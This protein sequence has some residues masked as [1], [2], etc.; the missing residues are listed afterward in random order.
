MNDSF[1]ATDPTQD[2]LIAH[3]PPSGFAAA[4]D[5][6]YLETEDKD[7]ETCSEW[8]CSPMAVVAR[9]RNFQHTGWSRCIELTDPDG[10]VHRWYVL[11][12][13]LSTRSST[14]L[15]G[16][17]DRGLRFAGTPS[18]KRHLL[19][20]IN[21]WKPTRRYVTT[22][23]LGWTD[24]NCTSFV[25][26]NERV[27]G[28]G[29]LVFLN[30]SAR[31]GAEGMHPRGTLKEWRDAVAS[32]CQGNPILVASVSLAFAGPLPGLL[33]LE[34]AGLHL[35]GESSKGKSSAM[36]AA[37][38][39][40]GSPNLM[41]SWRATTNALEGA[42]AICNGALMPFDEFGEAKGKEIG[43]AIYMLLNGQGKARMAST[44]QLRAQ[45][46]WRAM[47]LSTGELTL[48]DKMAEA[49]KK[50]MAGQE[51]R[52]IDIQADARRFGAFDDLHGVASAA[53]FSMQL[54]HSV[55][56][57][58]G[59]A[60]PEF[61]ERL[62][63]SSSDDRHR[64]S[65][66]RREIASM[67][68]RASSGARDGQTGRVIGHFALIALA[69]ELATRYGITGWERGTA[70]KAAHELFDNW[71]RSRHQSGVGQIDAAVQRT[72]S[73]LIAN[74]GSSFEEI[75]GAPVA[76]RDGYRDARWF[77]IFGDAWNRIH[78]GHSP[79]EQAR[80]L[81]AGGWLVRGDGAN[82]KSKTPFGVP[83]RPRAFK[84]KVGILHDGV[85]GIA[86]E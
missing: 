22:D 31:S 41:F 1:S 15:A 16:L 10:V 54:K 45:N 2:P 44:G 82:L 86:A 62:V 8:L 34:P 27:I 26:G 25:L 13:W 74:G 84:I 66:F 4:H 50:T 64:F 23:R 21:R 52:L 77:Y 85:D 36:K 20:L 57:H 65:G 33:D 5:G 51:V 59:T 9:G 55:G 19:D 38:S 43:D 24:A 61:V 60:G 6:I 68:E 53:E 30:E 73:F 67:I 75:G 70:L 35:R 58:Y 32:R 76:N 72:R 78:A 79:T 3:A 63:K 7:G 28:P 81:H 12:S 39:V 80:H 14:V 17:R 83:G 37:I 29:D 49:G 42:A 46:R 11:D 40:W 69:G 71:Q 48:A 18:A 56:K 47:L